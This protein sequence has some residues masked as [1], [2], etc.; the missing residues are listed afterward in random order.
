[1]TAPDGRLPDFVIMGAAKAGT[2]TLHR[3]LLRHPGVFMCEPKEPEFFSRDD[4]YGRGLAWYRSLFSG[5][6]SDQVCGEASTTYTRW[7]HTADAAPRLAE[8]VPAV[9]LVYILRHPVDRAYSHYAHHMRT[10]VTMTFEEALEKSSIYVDCGLYL[11]QMQR[12][13]ERI[14]RERLLCLFTED[15][16]KSPDATLRQ[17]QEFIGCPPIDLC[18]DGEVRENASGS[19]HF[20]RS[21]TT[22]RLRRIPGGNLLADALPANLRKQMFSALSASPFGRRLRGQHQME[23]MQAE[24]RAAL[25][26]RFREPNRQLADFLGRDLSHWDR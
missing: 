14:P 4:Y 15:L 18:G 12:H 21:R 24:T 7:P 9:R 10:G 8:A 20:V 17:L 13:L 11:M 6:R 23:P 26:E 25:V 3:Y 22:Q 1:M 16:Q 5:A 19:D 2:T